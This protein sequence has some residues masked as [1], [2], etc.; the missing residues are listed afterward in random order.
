MNKY[1][2]AFLDLIKIKIEADTYHVDSYGFIRF[3]VD[4]EDVAIVNSQE[5]LYIRKAEEE[6]CT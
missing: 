1:V 5:M 2:V 3:L 6:K 4:R